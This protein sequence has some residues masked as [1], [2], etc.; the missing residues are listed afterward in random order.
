MTSTIGEMLSVMLNVTTYLSMIIMTLGIFNF[1]LA[2]KDEDA[3]KKARGVMLLTAG[4]AMCALKP[5]MNAVFGNNTSPSTLVEIP[6][7]S[8]ELDLSFI[9][10]ELVIGVIVVA[11][12]I[13][14]AIIYKKVDKKEKEEKISQSKGE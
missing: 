10:T 11:A 14:I 13:A 5:I 7:P 4:A 1:V 9:T 6:K 3:D 2:F 8:F 12:L